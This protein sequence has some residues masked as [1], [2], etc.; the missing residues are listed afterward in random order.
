[1]ALFGALAP[2]DGWQPQ[3][4]SGLGDGL[5]GPSEANWL[6]LAP[7]GPG[8]AR[9]HRGEEDPSVH[10]FRAPSRPALPQNWVRFA[11]SAGRERGR[12]SL[13]APIPG[14]RVQNW[15]RFAQFARVPRPSGPVS[16]G[17]IGFVLHDWL[18][19]LASFRTIAPR[20]WGLVP[21]GPAGNWVRFAHWPLV[22][23]PSGPGPGGNWVRF[24]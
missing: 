6:C 2:R 22:P 4:P 3:G 20:P 15:V 23:R 24:A 12:R 5:P 19:K 21:P 9:S 8:K 14:H 18:S 13:G 16:A 1:L 11:Q 10:G 7:T 17:G